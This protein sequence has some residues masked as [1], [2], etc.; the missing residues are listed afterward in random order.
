M[1]GE[2]KAFDPELP[3]RPSV[4]AL[5][6]MDLVAKADAK[7][8]VREVEAA[9]HLKVISISAEK[10]AGLE[11]LVAALAAQLRHIET[12]KTQAACPS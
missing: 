4:V 6:K 3:D 10:H 12:Q 8:I 2:L 7:A 5:N 9:T 1:R 11:P